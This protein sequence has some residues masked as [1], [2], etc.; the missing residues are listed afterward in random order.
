MKVPRFILCA[1][2]LLTWTAAQAQ[3]PAT[4][5][6]AVL[7][8][9]EYFQ[10]QQFSAGIGVLTSRNINPR[11]SA[12]WNVET[13]VMLIRAADALRLQGN[14]IDEAAVLA[15]A[16][17]AFAQAEALFTAATPPQERANEQELLGRLAER[18]G[19]RAGARQ[20]YQIA[21]TLSPGTGQAGDLLEMINRTLAEV[22]RKR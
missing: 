16:R 18:L 14:F 15:S 1:A 12:A 19:D 8:S 22:A 5:Q 9:L 17:A 10:A 3:A 11:G 13:A 7:A 2:F 21:L 20:Y 4:K 6:D